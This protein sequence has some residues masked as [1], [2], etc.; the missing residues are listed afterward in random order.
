MAPELRDKGPR[1][2]TK[3]FDSEAV[4]VFAFGFV[5]WECTA[6]QD[7]SPQLRMD[8]RTDHE[9]N[10]GDLPV[11]KK[12][13]DSSPEIQLRLNEVLNLCWGK[14]PDTRPGFGYLV[15][16][17]DKMVGAHCHD[18]NDQHGSPAESTGLVIRGQGLED[19]T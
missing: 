12:F 9:F 19:K 16:E 3:D 5:L 1:N 10:A 7:L 6:H 14:A 17:L 8:P 4:D 15:Q 13:C 18:R 2:E 11:P